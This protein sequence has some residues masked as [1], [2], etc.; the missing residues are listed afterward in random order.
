MKPLLQFGLLLALT[1]GSVS[2]QPRTYSFG[3][4]GYPESE[5]RRCLEHVE[6]LREELRALHVPADGWRW[7]IVRA[8]AWN[9]VHR[10][11]FRS[12]KSPTGLGRLDLKT[13]WLHEWLFEPGRGGMFKEGALRLTLTHELGHIWCW[14]VEEETAERIAVRLRQ[15]FDGRHQAAAYKPEER[16]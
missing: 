11:F 14:C 8:E 5:K 1:A 12:K 7:V 10:T 6:V 4:A 15:I 13:T 3:C 9:E 16:Q 2:A